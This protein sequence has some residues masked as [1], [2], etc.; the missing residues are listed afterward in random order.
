MPNPLARRGPQH[1]TAGPLLPAGLLPGHLRAPHAGAVHHLLPPRHRPLDP[2]EARAQ[3]RE[4]GGHQQGAQQ[5]QQDQG[6][7]KG[8][9]WTGRVS[10]STSKF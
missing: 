5:E 9:C 1:L 3:R 2:G 4:D 8:Q 6:Q 10:P 7:E